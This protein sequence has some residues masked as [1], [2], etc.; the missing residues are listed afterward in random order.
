MGNN[1]TTG[2]SEFKDGTLAINL[3]HQHYMTGQLITGHVVSNLEK[4]F[5][6][7]SIVV[8]LMGHEKIM[9]DGH[10]PRALSKKH[11]GKIFM[12]T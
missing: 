12:K 2:T 1:N 6:A 4:P 11:P 7:D 9:W 3:D 8:Q 5:P 10:D